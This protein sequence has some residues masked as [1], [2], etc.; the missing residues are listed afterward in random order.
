MVQ[1]QSRNLGSSIFLIFIWH[2]TYILLFITLALFTA[3]WGIL[4]LIFLGPNLISY[5]IATVLTRIGIKK[6]NKTVL[7]VSAGF[8]FAFRTFSIRPGLADF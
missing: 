7:Y 2:F 5:A 3:P 6:V 8:L 4:F 1:K